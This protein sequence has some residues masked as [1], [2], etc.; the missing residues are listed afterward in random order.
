MRE[1]VK[2]AG[3]WIRFLAHF[4]DGLILTPLQIVAY[5]IGL[6][7]SGFAA[8]YGYPDVFVGFI[9][10]VVSWVLAVLFAWLYSAKLESSRWQA[11][12]GK[13]IFGLKVTDENYKR[14]SFARAT[15]RFFG[16][17]L[18]QITLFIG[19]IMVAFEERKRGLHDFLAKTYVI[20]DKK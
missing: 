4:I 7:L 12:V 18:S 17:M 19:F 5:G 16:K 20:Y 3:F 14:I 8:L 2:Y 10:I 11:T 6:G 9:F 15:G 13:H 1:K